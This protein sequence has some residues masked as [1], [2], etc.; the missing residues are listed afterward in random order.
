MTELLEISKKNPV[1]LFDGVCNLCNGF[2]Q[3]VIERDPNEQFLFV[4]L[5]SDSAAGI[6]QHLDLSTKDL[7]T[8]ILIEN[9]NIYTRSTAGLK[10]LK[11]LDTAYRHFSA[12]LILPAALRDIIYRLISKNRYKWFG[13]K[14]SCMTPTPAF[15]SR[16]L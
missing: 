7:T 9:G 8:A 16:F 5:Q 11:R 3:F 4:T 14:D 12:L 2:V 1:L 6:I 10:T 13:K 15:Q